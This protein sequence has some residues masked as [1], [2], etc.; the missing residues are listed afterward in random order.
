MLSVY[1]VGDKFPKCLCMHV[2]FRETHNVSKF[3]C[4]QQQILKQHCQLASWCFN[5]IKCHF[6]NV[7]QLLMLPIAGADPGEVKWVNFHPL[8]LS[9]LLSFLFSYLLN[10]EI[11]VDFS[12]IITKIHPP[13]QNPGSALA[14]QLTLLSKGSESKL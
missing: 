10:I 14:L 3:Y 6:L 5:T 8:F 13:F 7:S 12:D 11:I 4:I 9:P 1:L 2:I